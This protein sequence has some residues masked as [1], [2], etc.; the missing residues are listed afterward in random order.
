VNDARP[1]VGDTITFTVTLSNLGKDTAT[2]VTIADTLPAGLAFLSATPAQGSYDPG[3]GIWDVGSLA[4]L[5]STTLAITALVVSG[6]AQTN[7]ASVASANEF[8]PDK[9]N[10]TASVTETPL[11]AELSVTKGVVSATP[12]VG[13][14][15]TYTIVV[16]NAG[17]DAA[18]NTIASDVFPVPGLASIIA[19]TPSQGTYDPTTGQ[20][21]IGD[22]PSGADATI[23]FT[24]LTTLEGTFTNTVTVSTATFEP[25]LTNNTAQATITVL[26]SGIIIGS[27]LGCTSTP[28][29]RVIDPNTGVDRITPFFAYEPKYRGGVRVYGADV[30][31]DGIPEILTAPGQGRPGEVRVFSRDGTPLPQYNFFPFGASYRGGVEIAVGSI[32]GLGTTEIVAGQNRGG[33]A[34]VFTVNP[35]VGVNSAAIRQVQPFGA[36]YR[37][38]VMVATADIGTFSG[39]TLTSSSP[40]GIS[41]MVFGSGPGSQAT[42][43]EYNGVSAKPVLVNAFNAIA[44]GYSRG[45]SVARLPGASGAAD[46][47]LVSAGPQ[48]GSKVQTFRGISKIPAASFAAYSGAAARADVFTAAISETEI[49][50]VQGQFGATPSMTSPGVKKNTAI[51]GGTS[52]T[53]RGT[54]PTALIPPLR[55][56]ILR[57]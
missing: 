29:V 46:G 38:G 21:D 1:N 17:P 22:L 40:D 55:V 2:G 50:S 9:T 6:V 5:G 24:A 31:G 42:V 33:L 43:R 10:N 26:A 7:V 44:K 13:D 23:T 25:D 48:G 34:R 32:T 51:T 3:T 53:L 8:D 18:V 20:W 41:E 15:V 49:F 30:T 36:A 52:S 16:R 54:G 37:S 19:G 39:K 35:G 4:S 45:V 47:V 14:T 28:L 56:G 12:I 57:K 11:S 27:D